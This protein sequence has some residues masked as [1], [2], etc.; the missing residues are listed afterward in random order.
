MKTNK[1]IFEKNHDKVFTPVKFNDSE[2]GFF[3]IPCNCQNQTDS[4]NT[5]CIY[6]YN[7]DNACS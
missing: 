2:S 4:C 6:N 7:T 1:C 3:G 5:E